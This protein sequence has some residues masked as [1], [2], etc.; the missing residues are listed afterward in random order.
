MG[1]FRECEICG[2]QFYVQRCRFNNPEYKGRFCSFKCK[3]KWQAGYNKENGIRP[4]KEGGYWG[5]NNPAWR[6]GKYIDKN[7]GYLYIRHN[8][9]YA[10]EHRLIMERHLGR[11]LKRSETIH[12]KNGN[13]VDNR[14]ENHELWKVKDPPGVRASGYHCPGCVC[15]VK[16]IPHC[17]TCT[18]KE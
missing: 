7:N 18:C 12:H 4:T 10:L 6:G 1:E 11:T 16:T 2:K 14:I 3:G 9:K 13:K 8:G 17:P 15:P 5:E